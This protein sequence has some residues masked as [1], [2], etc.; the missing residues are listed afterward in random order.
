M[1]WIPKKNSGVSPV[2]TKCVMVQPEMASRLRRWNG[3]G[4]G[5]V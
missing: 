1:G 3:K 2:T 5:E 4:V